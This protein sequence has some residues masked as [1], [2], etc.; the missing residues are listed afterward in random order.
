MN[1]MLYSLSI[2]CYLKKALPLFFAVIELD[3]HAIIICN[4]E[5]NNTYLNILLLICNSVEMAS[6]TCEVLETIS[7]ARKYWKFC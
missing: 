6:A 4:L 2:K 1:L 3:L 5:H 7:L